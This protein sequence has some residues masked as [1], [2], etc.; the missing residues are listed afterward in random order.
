MKKILFLIPT[1]GYG[2]AEKVLVNLVNNIDKSKFDVTLQVLFD[3]GI[4]KQFLNDSVHYKYV[5][6][7][8]IRGNSKIFG[9][10]KP[11]TLYKHFIKE[12]YD[13]IISYLEGVCARVASGCTDQTTKKVS[14][15]HCKIDCESEASVGFRNFSEAKQCYNKFDNT[16]CVSNL[17]KEYF[18]KT[19]SFKNSIEVLYNTIESD[20]IKAMSYEKIDDVEFSNDCF[21]I[22]SV[23]KIAKVKGFERLASIHKKLLDNGIKNKIYILGVGEEQKNIEDYLIKNN[24]KNSFIFLGYRTNPYKYV[25]NCDLYVCSSYSE[26]FSTSVTEA[27]IVGTPVVTTFCS[28]MQ[29]MLGCNNEY[30]I[31]TENSEIGLYNGIEKILTQKQLLQHY[32]NQAIDRGKAFDKNITTKAVENMI[33]KLLK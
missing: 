10:F 14:W 29:E 22:C 2:G 26:G 12:H 24:I 5:F 15:I 4:N 1:L 13:V 25:K 19:M 11:E 20:K 16:V 9:L 33:E 7:K 17:V 31:I 23:G 30:G 6:K 28:G 18:V 3:E 21:N 32:K 8:I 27:L